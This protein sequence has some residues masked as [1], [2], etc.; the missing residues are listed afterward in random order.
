MQGNS[1]QKGLVALKDGKVQLAKELFT[2]SNDSRAKDQ[3]ARLEK[4]KSEQMISACII[5]KNNQATIEECLTSLYKYNVEIVIADTGSTDKT[6]ELAQQFTDKV[7]HFDWIDDFAAARNFVA[8]KASFDYILSLDSDEYLIEGLREELEAFFRKEDTTCTLGMYNIVNILGKGKRKNASATIVARIYNR[9]YFKYYYQIH[10][11]LEKIAS[12]SDTLIYSTLDLEVL[13]YGYLD[14][15]ISIKKNKRNLKLL[16]KQLDMTP[17]NPY[18]IYQTA[19]SYFILGNYNQAFKYYQRFFEIPKDYRLF[20]LKEALDTYLKLCMLTKNYVKALEKVKIFQNQYLDSFG[21]LCLFAEVYIA[22]DQDKEAEK[23]LKLALKLNFGKYSELGWKKVDAYK[24]LAQIFE[25]QGKWVLANEMFSKIK[26]KSLHLSLDNQLTMVVLANDETD[27][28]TACL[29]SLAVLKANYLII[30]KGTNPE[31]IELARQYSKDVYHF[32][33]RAADLG[34]YC[35]T[36]L[37]TDYGLIVHANEKLL[38]ADLDILKQITS[39]KAGIVGRVRVTVPVKD[40]ELGRQTHELRL[41]VKAY[42][43]FNGPNLSNITNKKP[44]Q[45]LEQVE[46]PLILA[47]NLAY[48]E[49]YQS[50]LTKQSQLEASLKEKAN[51]VGWYE[52]AESHYYLGNYAAASQAYFEFLS[53]PLDLSK[54]EVLT[55]VTNLILALIEERDYQRALE[56]VNTFKPYYQELSDFQFAAGRAYMNLARFSEALVAFESAQ[57]LANSDSIGINTYLSCYQQGV[58]YEVLGK[59]Q[60]A[61]G[62]YRLAGKYK[63]AQAGIKR[64]LAE[65]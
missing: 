3:L 6:V 14:K 2:V 59:K 9:Q 45:L 13:H 37:K 24:E 65:K 64:L 43:K 41:L 27:K 55:A 63:L 53:G 5:T 26:D 54:E 22:N 46:L 60:R 38:G 21:M 33:G 28:L 17:N 49:Y 10:E 57:R 1:Y 19:K 48:E 18:F 12:R 51:P 4:R 25:R 58:I 47:K 35:L 15:K 36:K 20:W 56:V 39:K 62:A 7:Y 50:E 61:I 40:D 42:S 44:K 31:T 32:S 52:L 34:N 8:S 30:V 16:L 11:Q 23:V 29:Q